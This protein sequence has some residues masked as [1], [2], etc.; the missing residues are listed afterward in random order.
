MLRALLSGLPREQDVM[1][2]MAAPVVGL[3]TQHSARCWLASMAALVGTPEADLSY[4]GRWSPTTSKGYVR[5]AT[6]VIMRVQASVAARLQRD[7]ENAGAEI[8]G[9]QAAYLELRRELLSRRFDE[10]AIDAQLDAMQA[11]TVQLADAAPRVSGGWEPSTVELGGVEGV[12]S[13]QAAVSPGEGSADEE[14]LIASPTPPIE[15]AGGGASPPPLPVQDT[16]E[17]L[18]ASGYVVSLSRSDWRRLHRFGGCPRHPGVHYLRYELL[19]TD[20]PKQED[21]DDYC[22]QCWK[23]SDPAD[24]TDEDDSETDL[25]EDE[26]PMLVEELPG[27]ELLVSAPLG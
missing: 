24:D 8:T 1:S 21:Y 7:L 4:L 10:E 22:K 12:P 25:D 18:P 14:G 13:L 27:Q 19:G 9:E 20:K 15:A 5:T 26:V 17:A 6:E 11:W 23:N 3:F 2:E 16:Q